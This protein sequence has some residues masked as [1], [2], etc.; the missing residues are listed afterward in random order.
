[1][2]KRIVIALGGNALGTES[3]LFAV[4]IFAITL[5]LSVVGM[6]AYQQIQKRL[7]TRKA[8]KAGRE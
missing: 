2:S 8:G 6:L 1:M 5:A 7:E 3:Y 4:A